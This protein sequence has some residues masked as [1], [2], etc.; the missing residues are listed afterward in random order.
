M[1]ACLAGNG[2]RELEHFIYIIITIWFSILAL[3][4]VN[5]VLIC[6]TGNQRFKLVHFGC[7]AGYAA[8]VLF[9]RYGAE[10]LNLGFA[11]TLILGVCIP[12]A[13]IYHFLYLLWKRDKLRS[14]QDADRNEGA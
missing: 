7:F 1:L 13:V 5:L 11:P 3:G 2:S 12:I 9:V 4:C 8:A 14:K 10:L 6:I